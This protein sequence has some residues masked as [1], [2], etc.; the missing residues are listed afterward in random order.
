LVIG[1]TLGGFPEVGALALVGFS[2]AIYL[3][4]PNVDPGVT[5]IRTTCLAAGTLMGYTGSRGTRGSGNGRAAQQAAI[6]QRVMGNIA[7]SQ[8]AR[9]SSKFPTS[10]NTTKAPKTRVSGRNPP[11]SSRQKLH[12]DGTP[13]KSQFNPGID[14]EGV[15]RTAWESGTPSFDK[16]GKFLGKRFTFDTPIGTSPSGNPQSSIFVHWSPNNGIHGVPTTVET[17]P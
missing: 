9:N 12:V 16:N 1:S 5:V 14:V 17:T 15:V 11:I 4:A 2:Y 10:R 3:D 7:R 8:A 13:G 6:R